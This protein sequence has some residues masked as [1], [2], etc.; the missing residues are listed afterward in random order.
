MHGAGRP[1]DTQRLPRNRGSGEKSMAP[2]PTVN[3]DLAQVA[4][5][6]TPRLQWSLDGENLRPRALG[7]LKAT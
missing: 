6:K 4:F 2:H 1:S 5:K 3:G 7:Q